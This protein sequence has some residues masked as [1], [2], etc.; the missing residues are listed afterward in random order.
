MRSSEALLV[1]SLL[2]NKLAGNP[3][4][5]TKISLPFAL[6]F[7]RR[8]GRGS[9][10]YHHGHELEESHLSRVWLRQFIP[11]LP[12]YCLQRGS[13]QVESFLLSLVG[14]FGF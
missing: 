13:F 5:G 11:K 12:M 14:G 1:L 7:L 6:R 9:Q 4:G 3:I 10:S 8:W 2:W